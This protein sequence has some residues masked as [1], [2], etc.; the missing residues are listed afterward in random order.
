MIFLS[1][2]VATTMQSDFCTRSS[3]VNR[4]IICAWAVP[5]P[6][7]PSAR[8]HSMV[9]HDGI[10]GFSTFITNNPPRLR[11]VGIFQT[12]ERRFVTRDGGHGTR[13]AMRLGLLWLHII[14]E[15]KTLS[16]LSLI[17][18]VT[19]RETPLGR[20]PRGP[21]SPGSIRGVTPD[22]VLLKP[23]AINLSLISLGRSGRIANRR[24][25]RARRVRPTRQSQAKR[26]VSLQT[27]RPQ[28][29]LTEVVSPRP[30]T[31]IHAWLSRLLGPR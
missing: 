12:D 20:P 3:R 27:D 2:H 8:A 23:L 5:P 7:Q 26:T 31:P 13:R 22:F 21:R 15:V 1:V 11:C 30:D 17:W 29:R 24:F 25:R 19:R 10:E 28:A 9:S 16:S 18:L 4:C 6:G 14:N